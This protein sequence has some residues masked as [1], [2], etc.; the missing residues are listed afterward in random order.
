M[1]EIQ[2]SHANGFPAKTYEKFFRFLHPHTVTHV[3]V[4]GI[5]KYRP[6]KTWR[7]IVPE[8]IRDIETRHSRPV[9]GVGHSFGGVLT[10]WAAVDRPDLFEGIILLDPPIF[11]PSIRLGMALV[12]A[13]GLSHRLVP[14]ARNA[15]RR[16]DKFESREHA[17]QYWKSR[18][19]FQDF[20]PE[21][22]DAY[23]HHGLKLGENGGVELAIPRALE[24]HLFATTPARIG[25]T[26][27]KVPS[28]Y[29][30]ATQGVTPDNMIRK[31]KRLFPLTQFV[32]IE[33]K[34]MFPLEQPENTANLI[35]KII[36]ETVK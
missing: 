24:S 18:P 4:L 3:D 27:P 17:Y 34:H 33:G 21:A 11:T 13:L 6:G 25:N 32:P 35:K 1:S 30:Y 31:H 10:L 36:E 2:F 28:F 12:S 15:L 5:G 14:I 26:R 19:F 20:D 22:F 29:V 7:P 8:L 23:T 9:W 16:R